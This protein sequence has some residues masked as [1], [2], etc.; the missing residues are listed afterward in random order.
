[1]DAGE[2]VRQVQGA[3]GEKISA[4]YASL[5]NL[6]LQ[7][8]G[9]LYDIPA[10][11]GGRPAT[12]NLDTGATRL[13]LSRTWAR[14]AGLTETAAT[15]VANGPSFGDQPMATVPVK[16]LKLGSYRFSPNRSFVLDLAD[17]YD[18]GILGNL[19][20]FRARAVIDCEHWELFVPVSPAD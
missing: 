4:R 10:E 15:Q 11:I 7:K 9:Q 16:T 14:K 5:T 20:L 3:S 17:D 8:R 6:V 1:M 2:E 19:D 18:A 12:L 13:Y